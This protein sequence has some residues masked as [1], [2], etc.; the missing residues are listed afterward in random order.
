MKE[1]KTLNEFVDEIVEQIPGYLSD[2]FT[3]PDIRTESVLKENNEI[4][5]ALIIQEENSTSYPRVYLESY[6]SDYLHGQSMHD[7]LKTLSE[8]YEELVEMGKTLIKKA[9]IMKEP[10][11]AQENVTFRFINEERNKALLA[12]RPHKTM[13][14]LA[15]IYD[16]DLGQ[17]SRIPITD[18][19]L[20][21]WEISLEELHTLALEN[22]PRIKPLHLETVQQTLPTFFL[23]DQEPQG[24]TMLVISN[25]ELVDGASAILY[26]GV[27]EE[28]KDRLDGDFYLLPS[29]VHEL[30]AVKKEDARLN[31]LEAMVQDVNG[32]MFHGNPQDI[33]SDHVYEHT[34]KGL[35]LARSRQERQRPAPDLS[36]DAR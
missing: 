29:S 18:K 25:K 6:Y 8:R 3:N 26:P 19:V 30:I 7:I 27:V 36:V 5:T 9:E 22:T 33:L 16:V 28:I 1:L 14:D 17:E 31:A 21:E 15:C 32:S 11:K 34:E 4:Y 10:E 2:R 24:P 35:E 20:N 23:S 12:D 13:G